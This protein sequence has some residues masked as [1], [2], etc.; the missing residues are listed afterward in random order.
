MIILS[1][2]FPFLIA[3]ALSIHSGRTL[4]FSLV[5][6]SQFTLSLSRQSRRR[7]S[8]THQCAGHR[9]ARA[10]CI[11]Q[12]W[13]ICVCDAAALR[14]AVQ[15]SGALV[16]R[17]AVRESGASGIFCS[18]GSFGLPLLNPTAEILEAWRRVPFSPSPAR[19]WL[20]PLLHAAL[21]LFSAARPHPPGGKAVKGEVEPDEATFLWLR[22]PPP[23]PPL[24]AVFD[25]T[26]S[27]IPRSH[28]AQPPFGMPPRGV[29][30]G[31]PF[32]AL[33]NRTLEWHSWI[34]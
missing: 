25:S 10:R 33:P 21:L 4:S 18:R 27:S 19:R 26:T 2:F 8:A 3:A 22:P 9:G 6:S 7:P 5:V 23:H 16:M 12:R 24:K 28:G 13:R 31:A 34:S 29:A 11:Y 30:A 32:G 17:T 14:T 1:F 15:E 20:P